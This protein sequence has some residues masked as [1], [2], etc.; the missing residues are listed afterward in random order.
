M[1]TNSNRYNTKLKP[2][3]QTLCRTPAFPVDSHLEDVW[4]ILKELIREAS[5]VFYDMIH[6]VSTDGLADLP[7][8]TRRTI[9]KYFNRA[10]YRATPFG[11]MA[12]V[13]LVPVS[14]EPPASLTVVVTKQATTHRFANKLSTT[15]DT[16]ALLEQATLVTT[17]AS[18]YRCGGEWRYLGEADDSFVLKGIPDHEPMST[19]MYYCKEPKSKTDLKDLLCRQYGL[20]PDDAMGFISQLV[21]MGIL[22]TD[23]HPRIT[24][25]EKTTLAE[26]NAGIPQGYVISERERVSGSL[27]TQSFGTLLESIP[28]LH[29]MLSPTLPEDLNTFK[30]RF[31]RKF[32]YR[33]IPLLVALDPEV[34][35]GYGGLEQAIGDTDLPID[36]RQEQ[37]SSPETAYFAPV[38]RFVLDKAMR[39]EPVRL[40]EM[41]IP[42]T[43]PKTP[44][45]NSFSGL[46]RLVDGHVVVEQ[47]GGA[48]ATSLIGRFSL[49]LDDVAQLGRSIATQE[50]AA[51][52]DVLFFDIVYQGDKQADDVSRRQHLYG[53]EL[54]ILCWSTHPQ[55]LRL[56]DLY[57][58]VTGG[59]V[60]LYSAEHGK[61]VVPRMASAYNY[62]RSD[63]AVFRFLSDLQQQ[64]I[65]ADLSLRLPTALPG[66]RYYPRVQY[67]NVVLSPGKWLIPKR[68]SV[69]GRITDNLVADMASWL[70]SIGVGRWC[71]HGQAD[72]LLYFDTSLEA[73][74]RMLL[75]QG[76]QWPDSYL[77]EAF[78]PV[79]SNITDEYG[80]EYLS[81]WLLSF[82]HAQQVYK[83]RV[84][85]YPHYREDA[86]QGSTQQL[87]ALAGKW[88][89]AEIYCHA[90]RI[91][92]LLAEIKPFIRRQQKRIRRWFFVRYSD[93][94]PHLRIRIL[95]KDKAVGSDV[96][97][98][99]SAILHP[100]LQSGLVQDFVLKPYRPEWDRYGKEN[101]IRAENC[102][103]RSSNFTLALLIRQPANGLLYG[104][105]MG[106]LSDVMTALGWA[107]T[108]QW[109]FAKQMADSFALELGIEKTGFK[110]INKSFRENNIQMVQPEGVKQKYVPLVGAFVDAVR[111]SPPDRQEILLADLFHMHINRLFEQNQRLHEC[112]AYQYATIILRSKI[113]GINRQ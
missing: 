68:F 23:Q 53:Y 79:E 72:Q 63:L 13:G 81:E 36:L 55:T 5:P 60:V 77:E 38:Y 98:D 45:P 75:A 102:F 35:V 112:M 4:E 37:A 18:L 27:S 61:R 28:V 54:P 42:V 91:N 82:V 16:E 20:S 25:R 24:G 44:L 46:V 80:K 58:S 74:V 67:K 52:P 113:S 97:E 103:M 104:S 86:Y 94:G 95:L 50:A 111:H 32:E 29:H 34:G 3:G 2:A 30:D 12:S 107:T 22:L 33:T 87:H 109:L 101:L 14:I 110:A 88:L 31:L 105:A 26:D 10:K 73:D 15:M 8:R 70:R 43:E 65:H 21:H 85:S 17:N 49:A 41:D 69:K 48:T 19:I 96:L 56:N 57:V 99:L 92:V 84:P 71:R 76:Q 51:N 39:Q 62:T 78:I 64:G 9:W 11:R 47:L 1:K 106:L 93:P 7:E 89:Y 6:E 108:Q 59:E 40:E 90:A 100:Y 66:L 83:P